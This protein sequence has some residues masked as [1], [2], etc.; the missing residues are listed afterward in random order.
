MS[1]FGFVVRWG[2]MGLGAALLVGG[3]QR[4]ATFTPRDE[5]ARAATTTEILGLAGQ[6]R[7]DFVTVEANLD[8]GV[9]VYDSYLTR[10]RFITADANQIHTLQPG[11]NTSRDDLVGTTVRVDHELVAARIECQI[12]REDSNGQSLQSLR[13]LSPVADTGGRLWALSPRF[14]GTSAADAWQDRGSFQGALTRFDDLR[15]NVSEL[16]HEPREIRNY[17]RDNL[18]IEIPA[19]ATVILDGQ[20]R[21]DGDGSKVWYMA[22]AGTSGNLIVR[23]SSQNPPPGPFTGVVDPGSLQGWASDVARAIGSTTPSQAVLLDTTKTAA[24]ENARDR[25][26]IQVGLIGG[27]GLF[28]FGFST[29]ALKHWTKKRRRAARLTDAMG[30]LS[31]AQ[32]ASLGIPRPGTPQPRAHNPYQQAPMPQMYGG[33]GR[34]APAAAPVK[35]SRED[36][37]LE[38]EMAKWTSGGPG[39]SQGNQDTNK[40]VA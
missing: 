19:D 34:S 4:F 1:L 29:T 17:A 24:S 8:A 32:A 12:V 5:Q 20:G 3:I 40:R 16:G 13:V 22:V 30:A 27:V 10:P 33:P 39:P 18:S 14:D 2:S 31:A 21:R 28:G 37:A 35:K 9:R 36:A 15:T 7:D 25:A 23:G 6:D 38:A 26:A 11:K